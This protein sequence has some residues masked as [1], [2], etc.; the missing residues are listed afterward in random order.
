MKQSKGFKTLPFVRR[1]RD[2][3]AELL[4]SMSQ[5]EVIAFFRRAGKQARRTVGGKS[6]DRR[7]ARLTD[8][9]GRRTGSARKA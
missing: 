7:R 4:D 6:R 2:A 1:V 8:P 5:A 9:G 3:Q